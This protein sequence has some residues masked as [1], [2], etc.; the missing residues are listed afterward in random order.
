MNRRRIRNAA[1]L[2]VLT[3]VALEIVLQVLAYGAYLKYDG[4]GAATAN[5]DAWRVLCI[6]DSYTFGDGSSDP[7][8]FSYPSRLGA[9]LR[10]QLGSEVEISNAGMMGHDS[11]DALQNLP[12]AL[13]ASKPHVVCVLIGCND[14]WNRP[15]LVEQPTAQSGFQWEWRTGRLIRLML[16]RND[17]KWTETGPAEDG[18]MFEAAERLVAEA[19]VEFGE[20]TPIPSAMSRTR[21]HGQQLAANWGHLNRGENDDAIRIAQE[22]LAEHPQDSTAHV[23]LIRA[24]VKTRRALAEE[25]VRALRAIYNEN[26]NLRSAT[27]FMDGLWE[28]GRADEIYEVGPKILEKFPGANKGWHVLARAEFRRGLEKSRQAYEGFFKSASKLENWMCNAVANYG[29]TLVLEDPDR[30]AK[31]LTAGLLL[32]EAMSGRPWA[33]YLIAARK[34]Q[35]PKEIAEKYLELDGLGASGRSLLRRAYDEAYLGTLSGWEGT[36]EKHLL[37]IQS[38]ILAA[39]ARPVYVS[40]PYFADGLER[41]MARVARG[42]DAPVV[43]AS[44]RFRKELETKQRSDLFVSDGHCNDAGY[45]ILAEE[46]ARVVAPMLSR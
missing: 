23:Q 36:L 5:S 3:L 16:R 19:R 1:I 43:Y 7:A 25:S 12:A 13:E 20:T 14:V 11:G 22:I 30:A 10:E 26:P 44:A 33:M 41:I 46:V 15:E 18:S 28:L 31:L 9:R 38:R 29:G 40:Y 17:Q 4:E 37:S 32:K 35:V 34:N 2:V 39:G 27:D 24:S 42:A 6:G 45:D 21:E 8:K